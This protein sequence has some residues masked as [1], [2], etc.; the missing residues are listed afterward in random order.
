MEHHGCGALRT[1][2]K[3]DE[4]IEVVLDGDSVR[5]DLTLAQMTGRVWVAPRTARAL[6]ADL[7]KQAAACEDVLPEQH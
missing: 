1:V 5:L 2:N 3:G 7:I 6:A 4:T